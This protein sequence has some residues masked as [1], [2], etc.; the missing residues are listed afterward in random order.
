MKHSIFSAAL[1]TIWLSGHAYHIVVK[2][3]SA[4]VVPT[5]TLIESIRELSKNSSEKAIIGEM[6][7][8][9]LKTLPEGD[10]L[11]IYINGLKVDTP[12]TKVNMRVDEF[13]KTIAFTLDENFERTAAQFIKTQ[14]SDKISV[15]VLLSLRSPYGSYIAK[16][17][18]PFNIEIRQEINSAW[19]WVIVIII[20][21]LITAG[22]MNNILKDDRNLYYSLGRTQLFY[23]TILFAGCYL[24]IWYETDS[25]ADITNSALII[26]GISA[27]TTA[28]SKILENENKIAPP[29]G[30]KSDGWF[31]DILSDGS[32]INIQRFQSV[33]FNVVFGIIFIQKATSTLVIPSF[34]TNALLLMGI[35]SGTYAGLKITEAK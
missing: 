20:L 34:D 11:F 30:A 25:L 24:Y 2:T 13:E 10:T 29:V 8:I 5:V 15:P 7:S 19:V 1:L 9:K 14:S 31:K 32:S 23:W 26:L 3:D 21:F 16:T 17:D 35:S 27:S 22:F 18:K 28:A 6:I 4:Q 12:L 33:I